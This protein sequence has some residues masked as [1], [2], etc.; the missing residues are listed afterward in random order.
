M[1]KYSFSYLV[2]LLFSL[3]ISPYISFSSCFKSSRVLFKEIINSLIVFSDVVIEFN[4]VNSFFRL[5]I[6]SKALV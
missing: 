5:D 1:A 2:N 6:T 3:D 4:L